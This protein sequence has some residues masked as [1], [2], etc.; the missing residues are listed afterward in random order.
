MP[1]SHMQSKPT[2]STCPFFYRGK[3]AAVGAPGECQYER[4]K[5]VPLGQN[6]QG[7]LVTTA[8]RT[9]TTHDATCS[10]HPRMREWLQ[11]HYAASSIGVD[12]AESEATQQESDN[13]GSGDRDRVPDA[14]ERESAHA[15]E[16]TVDE[17]ARRTDGPSRIVLK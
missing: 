10:D 11:R 2:C 6:A 16:A 9:P 17:V 14:Y 4:A 15:R 7:G 12:V 5:A 13:N 1:Q 8:V 3:T